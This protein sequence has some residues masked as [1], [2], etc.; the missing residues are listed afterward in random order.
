V[1]VAVL[2]ASEPRTGQGLHERFEISRAE[3]RV[4][5]RLNV[6]HDF[7]SSSKSVAPRVGVDLERIAGR[8]RDERMLNGVGVG[9]CCRRERRDVNGWR[10][11][12][13]RVETKTCML[14]SDC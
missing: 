1:L 11:K 14:A 5:F 8:G 9:R 2:S 13:T 10:D 12:E 4:V 7:C 3:E 6:Q